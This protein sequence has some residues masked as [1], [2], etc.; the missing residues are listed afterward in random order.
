MNPAAAPCWDVHL[1]KRFDAAGRGFALQVA[2]QSPASR[3]VLSGP[4]GAGKTQLL[5]LLAGLAVPDE[6]RVSLAGRTLCDTAAGL[7]LPAG[8]RRLGLVFQDYAL[9]PHLTVR[10]NIAFGLQRGWRNPARQGGGDSV[11]H[12][13]RTLHLQAVAGHLP[14]QVSGGQRQRTALGRALITQP[15]A[16]LLDEPFAALDPPLR[17]RL[18]REL[19]HVQADLGL[20]MLLVTHD[21][22]DADALGDERLY[23]RAGRCVGAEQ[24]WQ[25]DEGDAA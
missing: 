9:F 10:Q 22:A 7:C 20:P 12:W 25:D 23:L 15:S 11:D 17:Q 4:S 24:A 3:L 18:R 2:F 21:D 5:R 8:Q 6:G 19:A 14:H 1:N 16:L 13:L